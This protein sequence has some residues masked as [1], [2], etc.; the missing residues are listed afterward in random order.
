MFRKMYYQIIVTIFIRELQEVGV[1]F[2]QRIAGSSRQT[3]IC[4]LCYN[5]IEQIFKHVICSFHH[6]LSIALTCS[7]AK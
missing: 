3:H 7:G 2:L 1:L 4:V 6:S 5:M